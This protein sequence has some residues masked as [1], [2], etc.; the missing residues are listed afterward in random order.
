MTEN[1]TMLMTYPDDMPEPLY[2]KTDPILFKAVPISPNIWFEGKL[3]QTDIIPETDYIG[4][5]AHSYQGKIAPFDFSALAKQFC[6]DESYDIVTM[7]HID[8][9]MYEFANN[10]HPGFLNI[11]ERLI[12][13]LG[14]NEYMTYGVPQGFYCNYWIMK[15][16]KF[17][18]YREIAQKAMKLLETDPILKSHSFKDS[19]YKG[20][21]S[22]L[23]PE[24]LEKI[25]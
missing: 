14:Y 1:L 15:R 24:K 20:T 17:I 13:G 6:E 19:G 25:S 18:L 12:T 9:N 16:D 21:I 23:S 11:W 8:H 4:H 10:V 7:F 5:I 22:V 3:F 2:T